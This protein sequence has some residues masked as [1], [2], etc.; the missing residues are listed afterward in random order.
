MK[1][2]YS[3]TFTAYGLQLKKP[4]NTQFETISEDFPIKWWSLL[5]DAERKLVNVLPDETKSCIKKM[6][7]DLLRY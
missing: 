7:N 3:T 4:I 1:V 6:E 5:Y 2:V